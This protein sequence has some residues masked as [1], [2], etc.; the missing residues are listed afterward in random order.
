M[1]SF[2]RIRFMKIEDIDN[3]TKIEQSLFSLPWTKQDFLEAIEQEDKLYLCVEEQGN[4]IA[5]CGLTQ[6]LDEGYITNV[7]VAKESQNQGI[8]FQMLTELIML[9]REREIHAFTLEV[10]EHNI[11]ARK[12]Y[13]KLG[14]EEVGIRKNFYSFPTENAV[15]M[16]NYK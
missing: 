12:L 14:F 10:R 1:N 16:W 4:I 11:A 8:G 13:A 5:Y 15:I 3:V 6:I 2:Q 9:G 7:A